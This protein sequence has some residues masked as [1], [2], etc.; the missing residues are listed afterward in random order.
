M[1]NIRRYCLK[2]IIIIRQYIYVPFTVTSFLALAL[3]LDHRS[4]LALLLRANVLYIFVQLKCLECVNNLD[5]I[6]YIF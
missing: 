6:I 4:L 2:C 5:K 3:Y 1:H